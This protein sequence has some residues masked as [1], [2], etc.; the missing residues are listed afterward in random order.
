MKSLTNNFAER[1]ITGFFFVLCI[2]AAIYVNSWLFSVLF[3]VFTIAAVKEL[4]N[5]SPVIL[6]KSENKILYILCIITY[7]TIT[8]ASKYY[9]YEKYLFLFILLPILLLIIL[10]FTRKEN[11]LLTFLFYIFSILYGVLP[12]SLLNYFPKISISYDF[13]E[14][15]FLLVFFIIIWIND[16]AAYLSGKAFGKHKLCTSISPGK[17]TEGLIGGAII[18]LS[19]AFILQH[20]Y[21]FEKYYFWFIFAIIIIVFGTFGDLTESLLKRNKG[22]KDSGDFFPGHGGVLDR[23]DSTLFAAPAIFTYLILFFY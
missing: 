11:F 21:P 8:R 17:T 16:T 14:H 7:I 18:S 22:L 10:F 12:F 19:S 6:K 23:F 15:L 20:Y 13:P 3:L 9:V 5:F 1:T 2:L 4:I